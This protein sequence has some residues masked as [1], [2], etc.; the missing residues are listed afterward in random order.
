MLRGKPFGGLGVKIITVD[1]IIIDV[2][3][4]NMYIEK[5]RGESGKINNCDCKREGREREKKSGKVKNCDYGI[6]SPN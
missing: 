5:E 4:N 3:Y 6:K 2:I 1:L